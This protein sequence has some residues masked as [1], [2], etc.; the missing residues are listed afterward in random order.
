[1]RGKSEDIQRKARVWGVSQTMASS[2]AELCG[3]NTV[4]PGRLCSARGSV[5]RGR[6]AAL[7]TASFFVFVA[8]WHARGGGLEVSC[9]PGCA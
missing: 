8:F 3:Q 1:M 5:G 4:Q 6:G 7:C 2:D 9:L